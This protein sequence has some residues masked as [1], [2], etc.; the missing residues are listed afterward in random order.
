[1][2]R[3]G[4]EMYE[5]IEEPTSTASTS[6]SD[7]KTIKPTDKRAIA[8][9]LSVEGTAARVTFNGTTPGIGTGPGQVIPVGAMP[10]L[11]PLAV[12]PGT[13]AGPSIKFVSASAGTSTVTPTFVR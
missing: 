10:M 12:T 13:Q 2:P 9:W 7:V 3:Q 1:M 5:V 8:V 6:T 11:F 4:S